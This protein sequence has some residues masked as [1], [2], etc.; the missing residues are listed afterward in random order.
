VFDI[1]IYDFEEFKM[2][3]SGTVQ[4]HRVSRI[5][6]GDFTSTIEIASCQSKSLT[7]KSIRAD[8]GP[9]R[10]SRIFDLTMPLCAPAFTTLSSPIR[11]SHTKKLST[12]RCCSTKKTQDPNDGLDP[13]VLSTYPS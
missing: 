6:G 8:K 5:P 4:A 11:S 3:V 1:S 10:S 7:D 13:Q 2:N 9:M 12:G